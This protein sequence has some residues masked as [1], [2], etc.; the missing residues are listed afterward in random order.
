MPDLRRTILM[1]GW[2]LDRVPGNLD[3]FAARVSRQANPP[4]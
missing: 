3:K 2:L 1:P 4:C